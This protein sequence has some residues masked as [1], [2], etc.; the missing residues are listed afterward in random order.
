MAKKQN[1][2]IILD[3]NWYISATINRKSRRILY[4]ILTNTSLQVIYSKEILQEYLEVMRR[5]KFRRFVSINQI[6]RFI[7]LIL[8]KLSEVF[9]TTSVQIS[10]D[11]DDDY[12]LAMAVENNADYLITGD[13]DLLV[14]KEIQKTKILKMSQFQNLVN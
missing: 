13:L 9:I 4:E 1:A 6:Q 8:P 14:L 11:K 2:K 3:T 12:L 7:N 5:A 10:R